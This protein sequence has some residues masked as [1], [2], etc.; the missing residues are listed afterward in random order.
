VEGFVSTTYNKR[1]NICINDFF[2]QNS[3]RKY[4]DRLEIPDAVVPKRLSIIIQLCDNLRIGIAI[5]QRYLL[6]LNG[7]ACYEF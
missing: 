6:I 3:N 1:A 7:D 5:V 2:Y 4:L